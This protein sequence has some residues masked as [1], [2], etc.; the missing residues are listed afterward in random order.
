MFLSVCA[1]AAGAVSFMMSLLEPDPEKRPSVRTAMEERWINEG[2]A[3]K[4]LHTLSHKNR[5]MYGVKSLCVIVN[6]H[7]TAFC[8]TMYLCHESKAKTQRFCSKH[9]NVGEGKEKK[10]TT[11]FLNKMNIFVVCGLTVFFKS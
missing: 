3:K 9:Y 10:I 2:Y 1:R 6:V 11:C 5:Y 7:K 8:K 4:P